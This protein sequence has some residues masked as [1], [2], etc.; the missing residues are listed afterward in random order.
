[1]GQ[2]ITFLSRLLQDEVACD[3]IQQANDP[4]AQEFQESVGGTFEAAVNLTGTAARV[5]IPVAQGVLE[6]VPQLVTQGSRSAT[7]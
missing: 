6:S 2:K 5:G 3:F 4:Q 1:M 7:D